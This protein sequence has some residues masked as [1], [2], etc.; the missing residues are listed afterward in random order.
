MVAKTT[1]PPGPRQRRARGD[2]RRRVGH[3]LQQL[4][5]GDDVELRGH[6]RPRTPRPPPADSRREC[7]IRVRAGA[8]RPAPSPTGRCRSRARPGRHRL[9]QDAAPAADVEHAPVREAAG[10]V[11]DPCESHRIHFVQRAGTRCRCPTSDARRRRTSRARRDRRWVRRWRWWRSSEWG[12][13]RRE[14][15][16]PGARAREEGGFVDRRQPP[17][18]HHSNAADPDVGHAVAARG[19]DQVRQ[20]IEHRLRRDAGQGRPRRCRPACPAR[21]SRCVRPC[22]ARARR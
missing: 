2:D 1:V 13:L 6:L 10:G 3:V 11:L 14:L 15:L 4:H 7:R 16:L 18:R 19:E 21:A 5:A 8:R 12:V 9:R 17:V 22:P 20:R